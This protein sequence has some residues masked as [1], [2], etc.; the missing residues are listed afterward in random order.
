MHICILERS[1]L[2]GGKHDG[3][4]NVGIIS[5]GVFGDKEAVSSL[6]FH[7]YLINYM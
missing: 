2:R 7:P 4:L 5:N 6:L 1:P 3:Q